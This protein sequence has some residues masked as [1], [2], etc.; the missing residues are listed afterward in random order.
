MI[1]R[2]GTVLGIRKGPYVYFIVKGRY[3]YIGETQDIPVSRWSS[4]L[5]PT[6]SFS[7]K[8]RQIDDE[9]FD[10]CIQLQFYAYFCNRIADST[11]NEEQRVVTQY[12][13]HLLHTQFMCHRSLGPKFELI[14]DTKRTAPSRCRYDWA[15]NLAFMILE[16]FASDIKDLSA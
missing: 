12:V 8:L 4:H 7:V 5:I 16:A 11:R 9:I 1:S 14:S 10:K 13:E 2:A 3:V 6:G 15:P